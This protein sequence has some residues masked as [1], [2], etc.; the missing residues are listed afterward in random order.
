MDPIWLLSQ[1][2]QL[3]GLKP[4]AGLLEYF[5]GQA[6]GRVLAF[7]QSATGQ[8]PFAGAKPI[9]DDQHFI[10]DDEH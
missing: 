2:R 9:V 1:K 7:M 8:V 10:V 3:G 6:N 5:P 4:D